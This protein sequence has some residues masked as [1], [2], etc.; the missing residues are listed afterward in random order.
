MNTVRDLLRTRLALVSGIGNVH[1]YVRWFDK[2]KA[3]DTIAKNGGRIHSWFVTN[4]TSPVN[5]SDLQA[6]S[7]KQRTYHYC[8]HGL[9][10][11]EDADE[12]EILFEN[13]VESVI[14][15]FEQEDQRKLKTAGVQLAGLIVAGPPLW[16]EG[17]HRM[18]PGDQGGVLCHYA[19]IDLAVR[20]QTQP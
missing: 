5:T 9:M 8:F 16:N 12:T 19:K 10:S 4:N 3:M 2:R 17:G 18:W 11:V 20:V 13:V 14:S 6:L 1:E 7:L 15:Y